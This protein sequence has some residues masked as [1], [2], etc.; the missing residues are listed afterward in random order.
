MLAYS[1]DVLDKGAK[2]IYLIW[3]ASGRNTEARVKWRRVN[4][5][6]P[7][8]NIFDYGKA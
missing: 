4:K 5:R 2:H 8:R 3:V 6:T 7:F 1:V